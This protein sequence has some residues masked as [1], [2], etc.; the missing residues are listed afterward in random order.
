MSTVEDAWASYLARTV[1]RRLR[2][3]IAFHGGSE[4]PKEEVF[5]RAEKTALNQL[6]E[7]FSEGQISF[8]FRVFSDMH[9]KNTIGW[10]LFEEC[11]KVK[12]SWQVDA[13]IFVDDLASEL[14]GRNPRWDFRLVKKVIGRFVEIVSEGLRANP[15]VLSHFQLTCLNSPRDESGEILE[16]QEPT[17]KVIREAR[18]EQRVNFY[19]NSL[20]ETEDII[21]K[22]ALFERGLSF[23]AQHA[24]EEAI[25]SFTECLSGESD[26][27]AR[28]AL[29]QPI[30]ESYFAQ[31]K[32]DS[33]LKH[34]N[35]ALDIAVKAE[36][37]Q[38]QTDA[39][40]NL[41]TVYQAK[42]QWEKAIEFHVRALKG[43]ERIGDE[44]GMAQTFNNLGVAYWEMG[45]WERAIDFYSRGLERFVSVGDQHGTAAI[46]GNLGLIYDL[47]GEREKAIEF[48][49]RALRIF[50]EFGDEPGA[51]RVLNDLGV[52]YH[53]REEWDKAIE[54][55]GRSV[56]I[57]RKIH[58][59]N[60]MAQTLGNLAMVYNLKGEWDKAIESCD[61]AL[62]EVEKSGDECL[63]A[64]M[65]MHVGISY[66]NQGKRREAERLLTES[67]EA[68]ERT[69][70]SAS[71]KTARE[72]LGD[73]WDD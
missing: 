8:I 64:Q 55:Y 11:W 22:K 40:L 18:A 12:Q 9:W 49:N 17:E 34:W 15:E 51:A 70:D 71:A 19:Q 13:Q 31:G 30:G 60:E 26:L 63:A 65:K 32:K 4:D 61:R 37:Q 48:H 35:E 62:K 72:E 46:F 3:G 21:K 28:F 25:H 1:H 42:G 54:Y 66:K 33:A 23:M 56:K 68:F 16:S 5:Q 6:R 69:G 39:L 67:L 58:H 24:Y 73:L 57:R 2:N 27:D 36:N 29:L 53:H 52:V 44:H 20:P 14:Y 59:E 50:E 41:G 47:E 7:E 43:F 45:D 38:N 10:T